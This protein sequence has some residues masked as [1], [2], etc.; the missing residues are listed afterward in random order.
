M[1]A[2][3]LSASLAFVAL[4]P[5][6]GCVAAHEGYDE[7]IG[8]VEQAV[9]CPPKLVYY[10]VRGKHNNGYDKTAGNASL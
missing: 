8:E 6:V 7:P 10:P 1:R 2:L 9:K 5:Q 4:G 3:R